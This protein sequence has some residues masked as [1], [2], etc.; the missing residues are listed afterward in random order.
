MPPTRHRKSK[1]KADSDSEGEEDPRPKPKRV[2]ITRAPSRSSKPKAVIGKFDPTKLRPNSTVLFAG[3]RRTGK[4]FC[5]RD[6][7]YHN[8]K[9]VYDAYVYSGTREDKFPWEKFTP[10]KYVTY[11]GEVFPDADLK[12]ALD[13][14]LLRKEI[15]EGHGVEC[16]PTMFVF[17][18]L[19]FLKKSMWKNQQIRKIMFNGRH[20]AS[21]CFAAVQYIME[22]DMATRSMFD[23]AVFAVTPSQAYRK[24]IH[25][26]FGGA[27]PSF[28]EFE[29]IFMQCT[30]DHRVMV[31][32]C[33]ANEYGIEDSIFWYKAEDH[34]IFRVGVKG[35]WDP[36][37][38]QRNAAYM[39]S[40]GQAGGPSHLD[41]EFAL[42][43]D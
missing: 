27:V 21:V 36:A 3:G 34:G 28:K 19:E 16:P 30:R 43:E 9:L 10:E 12:A 26:Q 8:R 40:A 15:A 4:S 23:Y 33:R 18:D 14:Q 22:I 5:M 39:A 38:D 41:E 35:V 25:A 6:W 37:L 29:K 24:R 1:K 2:S 11:V 13:R 31:V 42:S 20:F 32:D 17:E 7:I